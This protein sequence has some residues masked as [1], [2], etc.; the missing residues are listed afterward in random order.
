M[1]ASDKQ[2]TTE[3]AFCPFPSFKRRSSNMTIC[4]NSSFR[5][6]SIV[7]EDA[8]KE[9]S[10]A[11]CQETK[12]VI[13]ILMGIADRSMVDALGGETMQNH[14]IFRILRSLMLRDSIHCLTILPI[15][16]TKI[17]IRKLASQLAVL[18]PLLRY[19]PYCF[20]KTYNNR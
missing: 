15:T 20:P 17:D 2:G 1:K 11:L 13:V 19:R 14:S 4:L 3:S 9:A 12:N 8:D 5:L 6:S 18:P 7:K 16:H 10:R